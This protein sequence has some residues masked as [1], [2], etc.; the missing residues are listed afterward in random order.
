[1]AAV[2]VDVLDCQTVRERLDGEFAQENGLRVAD[3]LARLEQVNL[4]QNLDVALGDLG[5]NVERLQERSLRR[6]EL[7]H[8]SRNED[9]D[10]RVRARFGR[11]R[12]ALRLEHVENLLHL[13]LAQHQTDRALDV[14]QEILELLVGTGVVTNRLTN[15]GVLAHQHGRAHRAD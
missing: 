10:R 12:N 4:A 15:H 9:V 1:M 11:R 13:S 7:R 5:L 8:A 6:F 3:T 2:V 14:R